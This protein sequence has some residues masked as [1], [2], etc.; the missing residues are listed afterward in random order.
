VEN[1]SFKPIDV[2]AD[3][4]ICRAFARDAFV[5]SFGSADRM[6]PPGFDWAGWLRRNVDAFPEG[7]VHLWRSGDII[8]E[9]E[10]TLRHDVACGYVLLFY[11][12]PEVRGTGL[13]TLLHDYT[14]SLFRRH[15]M[16]EARLSVSPANGRAI[17]Y[18]RKFGWEDIGPRKGHEHVNEMVLALDHSASNPPLQRTGFAG[19]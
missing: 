19:R 16:N 9:L 2:D 17:A 1:L 10:L 14:I 4:E 7:W 18:Y 15:G 3:L 12:V 6:E 5:C 11:L 13:G 8:G